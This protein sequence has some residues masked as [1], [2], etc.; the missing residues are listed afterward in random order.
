LFTS[1]VKIWSA[2]RM[3]APTIAEM[4]M[5]STVRRI[6]VWRSGQVTF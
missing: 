4:M 2:P 5:T 3:Y 1:H 6:T